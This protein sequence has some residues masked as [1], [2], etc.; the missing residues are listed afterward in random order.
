MKLSRI[1]LAAVVATG[2]AGT[3]ETARA[4]NVGCGLGSVIFSGQRGLV[5]DLAASFT[6][7]IFINQAFGMSTGTLGCKQGARIETRRLFAFVHTNYETFAMEAASG[8][9]GEATIAAA[10]IVGMDADKFAALMSDNFEA[11]FGNNA[12]AS[13]ATNAIYALVVKA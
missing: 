10:A 13:E 9:K 2:V 8:E 6:N 1:A 12:D 5:F 4:D 11:I 7:G 3:I